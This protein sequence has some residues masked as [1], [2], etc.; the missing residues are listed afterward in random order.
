[1]VCGADQILSGKGG[2]Y[3]GMYEITSL[4]TFHVA[5]LPF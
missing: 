4:E 3:T 5:Y 2:T 1:M